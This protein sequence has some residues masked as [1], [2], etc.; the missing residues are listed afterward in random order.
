MDDIPLSFTILGKGNYSV[1]ISPVPDFSHTIVAYHD[2]KKDDVAKV[3]KIDEY[4][5]IDFKK[6]LQILKRVNAIKNHADFTVTMKAAGMVKSCNLQKIT[7]LGITD[8]VRYVYQMVFDYGGIPICKIMKTLRF[9]FHYF[10]KLMK[11]FYNGLKTLHC[12]NIV[13]RDIKPPNVLYEKN[14]LRLIDFGLSCLVGDVYAQDENNFLL[15]SMYMYNPPEFL[16]AHILI[17]KQK[18]SKIFKIQLEE[19][20]KEIHDKMHIFYDNHYFKFNTKE[21]WNINKYIDAFDS[22]YNDIK[23][24]DLKSYEEL[25]TYDIAF[26]SDVYSS[27]F[28]IK[29][30]RDLIDMNE[31]QRQIFETLFDMTNNL[32]VFGRSNVDEVIEF[33]NNIEVM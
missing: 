29:A 12:S 18:I 14:K 24:S 8:N 3:F 5:E 21:G 31:K 16:L 20:F 7:E 9:E 22:M 1:V 32:N 10:I 30:F 6:E 26:K 11:G 17:K 23:N 28:I 25:F 4:S 19:A 15:Y 13:H 33:L 2:A 27:S